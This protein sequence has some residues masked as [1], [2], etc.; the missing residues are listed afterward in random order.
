MFGDLNI[1]DVI[2]HAYSMRPQINLGIGN[3]SIFIQT[4]PVA[5]EENRRAGRGARFGRAG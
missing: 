1:R 2:G 3:R 4:K 5:D